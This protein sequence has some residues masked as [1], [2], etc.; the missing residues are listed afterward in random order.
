MSSITDGFAGQT[1]LVTGAGH[2]LGRAI[3]WAFAARGAAV[4]A[5]DVNAA[6]LEETAARAP[7]PLAVR[8]VD[9]TD[10]TKVHAFVGEALAATGRIDVLINDA[11][12]VCGQVGRPIEEISEAD[13]H[14]IFA[15]NATGAFLAAQAVVPAM[16]ARSYGRI[17]TISSG[18]GLGVSLTGIQAY[19]AAKAAQIGL[20]RQLGHELGAFGITVNSVAPGFV[21]CNPATERQWEAYGAEGQRE[22]VNN[23]ATRRL[24]TPEDIAHAVLFFA[25]PTSGWITGQT[26]SVDGGK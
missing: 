2:G 7:A 17:V 10:R 23:I 6:G 16:K 15:V 19:A 12:G 24:G 4:W 21:R 1:V 26:L 14:A 5:C 22:L 25:A 8:T 9:V 13:W 11:G 20:T 3:A 18:A